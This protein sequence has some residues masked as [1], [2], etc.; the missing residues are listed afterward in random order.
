MNAKNTSGKLPN[1]T[2]LVATLSLYRS[3]TA[4]QFLV[5]TALH[6][7]AATTV[8]KRNFNAQDYQVF[9]TEYIDVGHISIAQT[10]S[11]YFTPHTFVFKK[12]CNRIRVVFNASTPDIDD[13][14]LNDPLSTGPKLQP[15]HKKDIEEKEFNTVTYS[16]ASSAFQAIR[17]LHQLV[18]DEGTP[19]PAVSKAILSE[20]LDGDIIFGADWDQVAKLLQTEIKSLMSLGGFEIRKWSSNRP[21]LLRSVPNEY[22]E[23]LIFSDLDGYPKILGISWNATR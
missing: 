15:N 20:S 14:S 6:L 12:S 19:F 18:L 7:G 22:V 21:P 17:V 13:I 11:A 4:S 16:L 8:W 5:Q 9:L 23:P 10:P 1:V 2:K 3:R